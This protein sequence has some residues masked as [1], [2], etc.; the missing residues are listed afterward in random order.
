MCLP[1]A[2]LSRSRW[3]QG[4]DE[5]KEQR[6]SQDN[7]KQTGGRLSTPAQSYML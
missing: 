4:K 6:I 7:R 1:N 3:R 5:A 2:E